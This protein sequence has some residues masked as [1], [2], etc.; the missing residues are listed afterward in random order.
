MP[1]NSMTCIDMTYINYVQSKLTIAIELM[2]THGHNGGTC[3]VAHGHV[4]A[5]AMYV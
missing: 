5:V 2:N 3:T 4:Q 1:N